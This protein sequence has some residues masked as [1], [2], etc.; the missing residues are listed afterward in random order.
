MSECAAREKLPAIKFPHVTLEAPKFQVSPF[1]L[2]HRAIVAMRA[3]GVPEVHIEQYKYE[4]KGL[5]LDDTMAVTMYTV[6]V[7]E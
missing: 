7:L 6:R 4:V 5:D 2:A 3:A 1:G